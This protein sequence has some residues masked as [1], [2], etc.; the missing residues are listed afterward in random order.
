MII[1]LLKFGGIN[2]P[3]SRKI[4]NRG[5]HVLSVNDDHVRFNPMDWQTNIAFKDRTCLR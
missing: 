4:Y 1:V 2:M 3:T 5:L